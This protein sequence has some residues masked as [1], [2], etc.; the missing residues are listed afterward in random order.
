[1]SIDE[2]REYVGTTPR[3]GAAQ[4]ALLTIEGLTP[5]ARVL[6]YGCGALHLARVLVPFLDG[7]HY[8]AVE[9]NIWLIESAL[10]VDDEL[11]SFIAL[12]GARF[13]ADT[14]FSATSFHCTFDY[15]FAHSVLSH[16]AHWQLGQFMRAA[17]AVLRPS[18]K[19]VASLRI[20]PDTYDEGWV[21]PS[22][23]W[24]STATIADE[25]RAAGLVVRF[26]D[27][28][29]KLYTS[30]CPVEVHDWIVLERP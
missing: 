29:R 2:A 5:E 7:G 21:Y 28:Y 1:M 18:G 20:G 27:E 14:N 17:A 23:S 9:P 12:R 19:I 4:L 13:E 30:M 3:S 15:V 6:E 24:F 26:V 16:A 22:V 8:C 10:D 25:A 11:A